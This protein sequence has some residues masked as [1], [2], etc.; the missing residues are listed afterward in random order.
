MDEIAFT[1][2]ENDSTRPVEVGPEAEP[3]PGGYF[4]KFS[5]DRHSDGVDMNAISYP[6]QGKKNDNEF[7]GLKSRQA[8]MDLT[9]ADCMSIRS[10][11]EIIDRELPKALD[12][13]YEQV[14]KTDE[15]RAFFSSENHIAHAKAA[16]QEHWK[17][18]SSARFDQ[19]YA[20]KVN[21]IG[22]VHAKIGL[23]PRWYIGGYAVVMDHL[24]HAIIK[25]MPL[26]TGLFSKGK[27][28]V[29][30]SLG[31]VLGSLVKA[32]F[33][34][35]D[36]TI[37]VYLD[38]AE[39]ARQKAR[40]EA[41]QKEQ[42]FV[43]SRF[44]TVIK[45][46][47][48]R[49]LSSGMKDALPD[50]YIP[51]RDDLNAAITSLRETLKVAIETTSIIDISASEIS[52]AVQDMEKRTERQ[53]SSVEKTAAA[54]EEITA[55]VTSTADRVSDANT[56]IKNCQAITEQFG[57]MT[58]KATEVMGEIARSSAAISD[59]TQVME[60]IASQTNLLALNAAVEAARA[61]DAGKGFTVL[62]QEIRGLAGRAG[63]ASKE[64]RTLVSTSREQV[65]T[66]VNIMEEAGSAI[67]TIIGSVSEI[68]DHLKAIAT[69][70]KEQAS[71]LQDVNNAV[72]TIDQGTRQNAAMVEQPSAASTNMAGQASQLRGFLSAFRLED[73]QASAQKQEPARKRDGVLALQG[74]A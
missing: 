25:D 70:T 55:T 58:R 63:E 66:G 29:A 27:E 5:C 38:E 73:F 7:S 18:I 46:I 51:L 9:D 35:M 22:T 62:A 47:A 14:R 3:I 48:E 57:I 26:K 67:D 24:I 59:I 64:V 20:A 40:D 74:G 36:L 72:A 2:L 15:T 10:I 68:S 37:S 33:L 19:A 41:I 1:I 69:A 43:C 50:A 34:E 13:F 8:F 16:Q 11:K 49:N 17:S 12:S 71:A 31:D 61:G 21:A 42:R 6:L 30:Q 53:V 52:S 44:G 23:E 56:F 65:T 28:M 60:S 4:S 54:I 39:K 32:V 45:D